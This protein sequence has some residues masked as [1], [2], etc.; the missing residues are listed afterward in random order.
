[1]RRAAESRRQHLGVLRSPPA[2][3]PR[4]GGGAAPP[5]LRRSDGVRQLL[6][7]LDRGVLSEEEFERQMRKVFGTSH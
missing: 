2:L 4:S 3:D 6:R 1:M 5:G 7:L